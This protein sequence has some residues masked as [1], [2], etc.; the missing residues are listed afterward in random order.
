[1]SNFGV[2]VQNQCVEECGDYEEINEQLR[3][4]TSTYS[5]NDEFALKLI[6]EQSGKACAA[7]KCSARCAVRLFN[8]KCTALTNGK[9]AGNLIREIVEAVLGSHIMDLK[10]FGLLESVKNESHREC[11]YLHTSGVL[12]VGP[13]EGVNQIDIF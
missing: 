11:D 1:M 12:F 10:I 8:D 4:S 7:L 2:Q 9:L 5:P 3:I 6:N 13:K